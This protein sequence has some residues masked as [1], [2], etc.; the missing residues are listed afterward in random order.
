MLPATDE[1]HVARFRVRDLASQPERVDELVAEI[2][3]GRSVLEG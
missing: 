3:M 1:D 2:G